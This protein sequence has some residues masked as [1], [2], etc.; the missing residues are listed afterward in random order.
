MKDNLLVQLLSQGLSWRDSVSA[1]EQARHLNMGETALWREKVVSSSESLGIPKVL[2]Q[3]VFSFKSITAWAVYLDS[4]LGLFG[5]PELQ[6][7]ACN[8]AEFVDKV[9]SKEPENWEEVRKVAIEI[10]GEYLKEQIKTGDVYLLHPS[11]LTSP[12]YAMYVPSIIEA[13]SKQLTQSQPYLMDDGL[14]DMFDFLQ[15]P[16]SLELMLESGVGGRTTSSQAKVMLERLSELNLISISEPIKKRDGKHNIEE[17]YLKLYQNC[18]KNH[19]ELLRGSAM[20][21]DPDERICRK[22]IE[23]IH[24]SGHA[25]TLQPLLLGLDKRDDEIVKLSLKGLGILGNTAAIENVSSILTSRST[26]EIQA[27]ACTT[28]G[29]LRGEKY[30]NKITELLTSSN[31]ATSLAAMKALLSINS[32][33]SLEIFWQYIQRF[34][35]AKLSGLSKEIAESSNDNASIFL[36]GLLLL[37][38]Q[39]FIYTGE[40]HF[41]NAFLQAK[42][43]AQK[44]LLLTVVEKM[45]EQAV[46]G[47]GRIGSKAVPILVTL[48]RIFP[49]TQRLF[50]GKSIWEPSESLMERVV[51]SRLQQYFR[52]PRAESVPNP[53]A[54]TIHALGLTHSVRAIPYLEEISKTNDERLVSQAMQAL[55]EIDIPA[56]DALLKIETPSMN[57]KIQK[58]Q[59]IGTIV[60]PKVTQWLIKQLEDKDPMMRMQAASLLA[61]RNDKSLSTYLMKAAKDSNKGVRA[62][63]ANVIIR[64]GV[65]A[66]PEVK[67][68]LSKDKDGNIRKIITKAQIAYKADEEND[69]WA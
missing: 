37:D 11:E 61:M 8:P 60:H 65:D 47:F 66:Y 40:V 30:L 45:R 55:S 7:L 4:V 14:V 52:L 12:E 62:G 26:P 58:I 21:Y 19:T 56:L 64:L 59:E 68:L 39:A 3:V 5:I 48:L 35:M 63:L 27:V 28:L 53:I 2:R 31:E 23:L 46:F 25:H 50:Q 29:Q 32:P 10:A 15:L 38:L 34:G 13:R 36:I 16:I 33:K 51:N 6:G 24:A 1:E 69:F 57:L 22:G 18:I 42:D 9:A 44:K 49:E 54:E 17:Q 43:E 20:S 41:Y 67:R